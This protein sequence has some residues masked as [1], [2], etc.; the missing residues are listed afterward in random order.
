MSTKAKDV[1]DRVADGEQIDPVAD[2]EPINELAKRKA[3]ET[4][5]V[6]TVK[7]LLDASR[8]RAFSPVPTNICTTGHRKLDEITGGFR[9]GE[10]WVFGADTSWGKS[11]WLVMVADENIKAG[12]KVLIVS[13][14]DDE[15][16]YGDRLMARRTRVSASRL[17]QRTLSDD[18]KIKVD[19]AAKNGEPLPVYM[20]ARGR[21][22][23]WVAKAVEAKVREHA[24]DFV[25]F[26]YL[27][28]FRLK[29]RTQDRRNEVSEVASL[30]R[31]TIKKLGITGVIFS[32]ITVLDPSKAPTKHSI[33]E[34]RDV[35]NGAEIVVLGIYPTADVGEG[36]D[37][38]IKGERYLLADKVKT[39]PSRK[40]VHMKWND[41]SACFNT[42]E[43]PDKS[44][45]D[46][47]D[48]ELDRGV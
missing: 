15:S 17:R 14:E 25:G 20:D 26:D 34:S 43:D 36:D 39:G 48:N 32:Q 37:K 5:R 46:G 10:V 22:A 31:M 6:L 44:R 47:F 18:E 29:K 19:E 23:E 8:D 11:S 24:I 33:K 38:L 30:L 28:E 4:P 1:A 45:N 12:K 7:Q 35:T 21:H 9:P 40:M 16:I 42:V 41:F 13:A 3:A 27:Q 2:A